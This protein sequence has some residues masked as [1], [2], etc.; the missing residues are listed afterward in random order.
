[1]TAHHTNGQGAGGFVLGSGPGRH[2][3]QGICRTAGRT[4]DESGSHGMAGRRPHHAP[5]G[6]SPGRWSLG[7]RGAPRTR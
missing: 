2:D 3:D 6:G 5:R 7:P 1:M 4:T